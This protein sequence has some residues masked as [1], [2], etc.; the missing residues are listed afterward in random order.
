MRGLAREPRA[1]PAPK[2]SGGG[3]CDPAPT[4]DFSRH[5]EDVAFRLIP[6][7]PDE[8]GFTGCVEPSDFVV[9]DVNL[10][11]TPDGD[12]CRTQ[13]F[14]FIDNVQAQL[15]NLCCSRPAVVLAS[16][17]LTRDPGGLQGE[18]P[19][20]PLYA[21]VRDGYPCRRMVFQSALLTRF[22][23]NMVCPDP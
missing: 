14:A 19:D 10:A 13:T 23:P 7:L 20:V 1:F 21:I 12:L 22:F 5:I 3:A 15:A 9:P 4:C 16:V 6:S 17:L 18:L 8:Y 11:A 2:F